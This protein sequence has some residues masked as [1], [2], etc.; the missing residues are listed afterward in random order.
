[1]ETTD[2]PTTAALVF[3]VI[4]EL[5]FLLR[6]KIPQ[7]DAG[8]HILLILTD[9]VRL[10]GCVVFFPLDRIQLIAYGTLTFAIVAITIWIFISRPTIRATGAFGTLMNVI[11]LFFIAITLGVIDQNLP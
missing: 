6:V 1:M 2:L 7:E 9:A 8:L 11:M 5:V 10:I 4:L 3:L